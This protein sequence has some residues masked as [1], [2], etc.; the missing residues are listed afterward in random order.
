M[1][2]KLS[3]VFLFLAVL[4][5]G[6]SVVAA[7]DYEI[8][9]VQVDD[10]IAVSG[11]DAVFVERGQDAVIEVYLSGNASVDNVKV[12]AYLGGYEYDD[13]EA[14]TET[15][16]VESGVDY[17]KVLRLS[18]PNDLEA[19]DDY[20]LRVRVFDDDNE[21]DESFTL[22][23][24]EARHSLNIQ[25]VMVR[26]DAEIDA[27][28]S[29]F[30]TVRV[31]NLGAKKEEDIKVVASIPDLGVSAR[32]YIDE[33][34]AAEDPNEDEEDSLSSKEILLRI[35]EGAKTGDYDLN[36]RVEYNRGHSVVT[37]TETVHVNGVA[38]DA[39]VVAEKKA[40]TVVSID[41]TSKTVAQGSDVSFKLTLANLGSDPV[42]Y[43]LEVAGEQLFADARVEPGFVTV[44]PDST[45]EFLVGLKAKADAS[46]GRHSFVLK[47]KSGNAVVQELS[48][49][50]DVTK[51]TVTGNLLGGD[52]KQAA[53]IGVVVLVVILV[54]VGLVIA[55]SKRGNDEPGA[56]EGQ[57]YYFYP[58]Y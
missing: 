1:K 45:A 28:K 49:S 3:A 30:V 13:V 10:V 4:L 5:A 38:D 8:D 37:Q 26:P 12:K 40:E 57:S 21:V 33:L 19:S 55:F 36:V 42:L 35:P 32:E 9:S 29:L 53:M 14:S 34:T 43:S 46:E 22:R 20:T 6:I 25:D 52:V 2:S 16:A 47:V 51:K 11:G 44:Q 50:A 39:A 54:I 17:R 58:K 56:G 27:G 15:F 24:K 23:I 48:V 18:I 41:S 7:S 31:E